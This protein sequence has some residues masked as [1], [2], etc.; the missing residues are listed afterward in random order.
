MNTI[1]KQLLEIENNK[2]ETRNPKTLLIVLTDVVRSYFDNGMLKN[3]NN[4]LNIKSQINIKQQNSI[5]TIIYLEKV[6][7]LYIYLTYLTYN[8]NNEQIYD[9]LIIYGLEILI[10]TDAKDQS[11]EI[12]RLTNL[13]I[14]KLKELTQNYKN[15]N[16]NVVI[17]PIDD[18]DFIKCH[19]KENELEKI[20]QEID[21]IYKIILIDSDFF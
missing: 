19:F 6:R 7:Y 8:E 5:S 18:V 14:L 11:N 9:N 12:V 15:K 2:L 21:L 16:L 13:I 10:Q 3:S 20:Q 1:L 4:I 17:L